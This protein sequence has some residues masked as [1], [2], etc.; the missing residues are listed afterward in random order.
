MGTYGSW[1]GSSFDFG[2]VELTSPPRAKRARFAPH[3]GP[4]IWLEEGWTAVTL[5]EATRPGGNGLELLIS[6]PAGMDRGE[7]VVS[8]VPWD[9]GRLDLPPTLVLRKSLKAIKAHGPVRF[10]FQETVQSP[11]RPLMV[12]IRMEGALPG[13]RV[14]LHWRPYP[15]IHL[16]QVLEKSNRF[17]QAFKMVHVDPDEKKGG[18]VYPGQLILRLTYPP[19]VPFEPKA[20]SLEK[21]AAFVS[22]NAFQ[23]IDFEPLKDSQNKNYHF[24]FRAPKATLSD[25]LTLWAHRRAGPKRFLTESGT[26]VDGALSYRAFA[27]ISKIEAMNLFTAKLN[28]GKTMDRLSGWMIIPAVLIQILIMAWICSCLI[29]RRNSV[30]MNTP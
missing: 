10:K 8:A 19:S 11:P 14:G 7:L 24:F 20:V 22:D 18:T 23:A 28:K 13:D 2:L 1:S 5:L 6:N 25:A 15:A 21:S 16:P 27:T 30:D 12:G 26:P 9:L 4:L 29:G 3:D 17:W